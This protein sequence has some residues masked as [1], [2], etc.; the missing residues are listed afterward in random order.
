MKVRLEF[1][2][3][4]VEDIR[5]QVL[6][7]SEETRNDPE[8]EVSP[9]LVV[10]EVASI[11]SEKVT[12]MELLMLTAVAASSGEVEATVGAVMSVESSSLVSSSL[13][14]S[15]LELLLESSSA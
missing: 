5:M 14:S 3:V 11:D 10:I 12:E 2:A 13:E 1:D 6:K 4:G 9:V 7:S 15:S 8:Q